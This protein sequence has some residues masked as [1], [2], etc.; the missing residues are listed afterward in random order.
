MP[1]LTRSK[2][3]DALGAPIQADA[4]YRSVTSWAGIDSDGRRFGATPATRVRGSHELVQRSPT[5]WVPESTPDDVLEQLRSAKVAAAQEGVAEPRTRVL[6]QI[7]AA[8]RMR[9]TRNYVGRDGV[10]IAAGSIHDSA[11]EFVRHDDTGLFEPAG[12]TS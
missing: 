8:R 11:S 5:R 9:A 3:L 12:E 10:V 2:P 7:P 6:G 1:S 4:L